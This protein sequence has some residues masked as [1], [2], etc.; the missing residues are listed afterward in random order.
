MKMSFETGSIDLKPTKIIAVA[1][2][3]LAHAAEMKANVPKEPKFFL[4]PPS[5]LLAHGGTVLLPGVSHRVDHEVEL[6]IVIGRQCKNLIEADVESSILGYTVIVDVTARDL[7][8]EAKSAGMPWAVSKGFD[9]FAPIGPQIVPGSDFNSA[10]AEIWLTVNGEYRQKSSTQH[11][12][13][14][15]NQLVVAVSRVMT[16]EPH[17]II[18]T[19]TPEGVGPLSAGDEVVAGVTGIAPLSFSVEEAATP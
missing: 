7:Q 16:L 14:S 17:D 9:T 5:S 13:F 18:A 11:M 2:N 1:R 3:Y 4:K 19:G 12:I 10:D 15:M 8:Q 6:A